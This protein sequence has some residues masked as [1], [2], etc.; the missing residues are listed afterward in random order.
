MGRM[1]EIDMDDVVDTTPTY[2]KEELQLMREFEEMARQD[3]VRQ[4]RQD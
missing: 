2:T 4:I 1:S 3:D